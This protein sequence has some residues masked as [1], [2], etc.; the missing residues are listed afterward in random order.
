MSRILCLVALSLLAVGCASL[1]KR[2]DTTPEIELVGVSGS[3]VL[4]VGAADGAATLIGSTEELRDVGA[5]TY[6]R[7]SGTLYG[8][9]DH[10]RLPTLITIDLATGEATVIGPIAPPRSKLTRVEGLAFNPV[11]GTLYAAGGKSAFASNRLLRV[12]PATGAAH[13]LARVSGTLQNEIDAMAFADGV[14]YAT[15]GVAG[16]T[17][18]YRIDP[19]TGEATALGEPF[20]QNVTDMDYYPDIYRLFGTIGARR[21]LVI[22]NLGGEATELGPTHGELDFEGAPMT[23]LAFTGTPGASVVFADG[24]ET[25]DLSK[26]PKGKKR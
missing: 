6:D 14:L 4:A 1:G 26:W 18:L 16:S 21:Q 25:G 23:A 5:L 24:F 10:T 22:L 12:D 3:H 15:D 19:A 20:T 7:A 17:V 9:N 8:V 13:E 2:R 11:D